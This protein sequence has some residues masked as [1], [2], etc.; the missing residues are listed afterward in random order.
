MHNFLSQGFIPPTLHKN[1]CI[2]RTPRVTSNRASRITR[3]TDRPSSVSLSL[4]HGPDSDPRSE[5][6]GLSPSTLL[7][8]SCTPK[9]H[10]LLD[11]LGPSIPL[12]LQRD[13]LSLNPVMVKSDFHLGVRGREVPPL[14]V[15]SKRLLLWPNPITTCEEVVLRIF[16]LGEREDTLT[17]IMMNHG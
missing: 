17:C 4:P 16:Q 2:S 5:C 11:S 3:A 14:F 13:W 7:Q 12:R 6:N 10:L 1:V 15:H 9:Y 8:I